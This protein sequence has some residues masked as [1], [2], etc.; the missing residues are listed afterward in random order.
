MKGLIFIQEVLLKNR[1]SYKEMKAKQAEMEEKRQEVKRHTLKISLSFGGGHATSSTET[2]SKLMVVKNLFVMS[3]HDNDKSIVFNNDNDEQGDGSGGNGNNVGDSYQVTEEDRIYI[4]N[5]IFLNKSMSKLLLKNYAANGKNK[6]QNDQKDADNHHHNHNHNHN[7]S[8]NNSNSSGNNSNNNNN[9]NS[10]GGSQRPGD[11]WG[12][13]HSLESIASDNETEVEEND[14]NRLGLEIDNSSKDI[15]HEINSKIEDGMENFFHFWVCLPTWWTIDHDMLLLELSLMYQI[16]PN[17]FVYTLKNNKFYETW[18]EN[19]EGGRLFTEWCENEKNILHR[20]RYLIYIIICPHK[21][22]SKVFL[23]DMM[24]ESH[25]NYLKRL[26]T[27]SNNGHGSGGGSTN[28]NI[29]IAGGSN[30]PTSENIVV[31]DNE[32]DWS[33]EHNNH[34]DHSHYYSDHNSNEIGNYN[35]MPIRDIETE[36]RDVVRLLDPQIYGPRIWNYIMQQLQHKQRASLWRALTIISQELPSKM[37]VNLIEQDRVSIRMGKLEE[38]EKLCRSMVHGSTYP[39]AMALHLSRFMQEN[40]GHD[41]ARFEQWQRLANMFEDIAV[42]LVHETESDFSLA[43]LIELPT[44]IGDK[45]VLD[46]AIQYHRTSFCNDARISALLFHMWIEAEFLNPKKKIRNSD[47]RFFYSVFKLLYKSP[48]GFYFSPMGLYVTTSATYM[49]YVFYMTYIT[50]LRIYPYHVISLLELLFWFMNLGY[51]AYEIS[52]MLHKKSEYFS[53]DS[54]LNVFDVIISVNWIILAYIRFFP[55]LCFGLEYCKTDD[56]DDSNECTDESHNSTLV[57]IYM[58]FWS[59]QCVILWVRVIGMFSRTDALGPFLRVLVLIFR[60]ILGFFVLAFVVFLGFIYALYYIIAGDLDREYVGEVPEDDQISFYLDSAKGCALY[61]VQTFL[62]QQDWEVLQENETY[63]FSRQRAQLAEGLIL[64]FVLIGTLLLLNL[65]IAVMSNTFNTQQ[66]EAKKELAFSKLET[67][68]DL[69][70]RGR[71][72]PPPLNLF[73]ILIWAVIEVFYYLIAI[74]KYPK[75][76]ESSYVEAINPYFINIFARMKNKMITS[77]RAHL[78][79]ANN[80]R[81]YHIRRVNGSYTFTRSTNIGSNSSMNIGNN[82]SSNNQSDYERSVS[83]GV[84]INSSYTQV[85]LL[86]RRR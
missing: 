49:L 40:A 83:K 42:H 47:P 13:M 51:I 17:K 20:L 64:V 74:V 19:I 16:N 11:A 38:I 76:I 22:K 86:K 18:L 77:D 7:H 34:S 72:M 10:T 41:L 39:T 33:H 75:H 30:A 15:S 56:D 48:V 60:D 57:L 73:A 45:S 58:S 3:D 63:N 1:E 78:I 21:P 8:K 29:N 53:T 32:S 66:Q 61:L 79:A 85:I 68:F 82:S 65:L 43:V 14:N 35:N 71:L 9:N 55:E 59:I 28:N 81:K 80:L 27:L 67:T 62:G 23:N 69:A 52:E 50:F 26:M 70:H 5:K 36:F 4:Q 31:T 25:T 2:L 84:S 24:H 46:I 44:D 6:G 12:G 54:I 37:M